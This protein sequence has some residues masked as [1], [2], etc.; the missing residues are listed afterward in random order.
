MAT[1]RQR[2]YGDGTVFQRSWDGLWVAR[3]DLGQGADGRR[4]RWQAASRT[5]NSALQ[6]LRGARQQHTTTG[7]LGLPSLTV[8]GWLR[9]WLEDVARPTVRPSTWRDYETTVRRHLIPS[10]GGQKLARLTPG[11]VRAMHQRVSASVSVSAANKAHRVLRAALSD[12]ER[13]GLVGRNAARL[14]RTPT[15]VSSRRALSA[16]DARRIL[17][18]SRAEPR[19]S[20]WIAALLTG[21]RQGELLGLQWDRVD[22][23]AG[24]ADL[25]WQLQALGYR[26]GCRR[27]STGHGCGKARAGSCP[28]RELDV[29]AGFERT[30][31]RGRLCLTRPKSSAG[32]RVIPLPPILVDALTRHREATRHD[33]SPFGLV[34]STSDG[35]PIPARDDLAAWHALLQCAGVPRCPLHAARHTT[36]TLLMDVGIDVTV[37]QSILGHAQPLT[38]QRYQHADLTMSRSALTRLSDHLT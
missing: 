29:P 30:P 36:A 20:R 12:A 2:H 4:R 26:H 35:G 11:D 6:S 33:P 16:S 5:R 31:L 24:T 37:I 22:L 19:D 13:E 3:L 38:T 17:A 34:W 1:D 9:R 18:A 14:V 28:D 21:A 8:A 23:D 7:T 15:I 27:R 32:R 10:L 25:A